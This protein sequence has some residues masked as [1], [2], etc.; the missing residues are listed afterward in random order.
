MNFK[1]VELEGK[2]GLS[3]EQVVHLLA[4]GEEGNR[5]VNCCSRGEVGVEVD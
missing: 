3:V 1:K 4:G 5:M 2:V